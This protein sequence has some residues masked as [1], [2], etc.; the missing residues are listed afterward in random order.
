[1]S[2][3]RDI[4]YLLKK[5][6]TKQPGEIWDDETNKKS[7]EEYRKTQKLFLLDILSSNPF[8]L[9]EGQKARARY[10][11]EKLN[12][13]RVCGKCNDEQIIVMI[14]VY[15]KLEYTNKYHISRFEPILQEYDISKDLFISFLVTLNKFHID[16]SSYLI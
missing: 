4:N 14:I 16:K 13:S 5:Y 1:M 7:V 10:L 6:E 15:V 11:V 2:R 12:F 8:R 9:G 3:D